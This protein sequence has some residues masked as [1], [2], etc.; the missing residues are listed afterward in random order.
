MKEFSSFRSITRK[1]SESYSEERSLFYFGLLG[2]GL[3]LIGMI[4]MAVRGRFIP[5]EG[6]VYKAVSFDIAIGI[7]ILTIILLVPL[8]GFSARGRR[9]WRWCSIA[10]ALYVYCV[11]NIQI[12]RGR[13]PRF[14]RIGSAVD[15]IVGN[16]FAL[17]AIGLI[18]MFLILTWRFFSSR[19]EINGS[20]L[21]L[22][23]RYG[24]AAV[25]L[26]FIV[27]LWMGANQG[28]MIGPRG[29]LLPLHA[30]GFH[31]LQAVPL[32]ALLL[33]WARV[34][35]SSARV[36]VHAA[37]LAW[38]GACAAI[39]WQTARG[40]TVIEPSAAILLAGALL[41]VWLLCAVRA[42]ISWRRA[43]SVRYSA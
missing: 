42:S 37:G 4:V 24:C 20:P 43:G 40:Y 35:A 11:E 6:Y 5:P 38:L 31:G 36:W 23:I 7:Y 21:L 25:L 10:L 3:G 19:T 26:A 33:G 32:V 22:G 9:R 27:G 14:S 17:S 1:L 41:L 12:Y 18:V 28:P 13:D 34:P 30:A 2:I 39:A 16:L 29:N 15:N 8:A